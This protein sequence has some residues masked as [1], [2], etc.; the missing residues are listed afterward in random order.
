MERVHPFTIFRDSQTPPLSKAELARLLG[1][2]R[3]YV[4][5][6]E[7]GERQVGHELLSVVAEKTGIAPDVI[8]PD[9]AKS[10]AHMPS[11]SVGG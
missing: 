8:R 11:E 4:H 2:S 6:V 5:R 3:S 9:L 1:V 7:I 10:L